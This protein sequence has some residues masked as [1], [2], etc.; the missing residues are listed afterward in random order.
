MVQGTSTGSDLS[1]SKNGFRFTTSR[2]SNK[3][4]AGSFV[5]LFKKVKSKG[6][7]CRQK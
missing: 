4:V 3:R 2:C 5:Y 6:E 7:N 1:I